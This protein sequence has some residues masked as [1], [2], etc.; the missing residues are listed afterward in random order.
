M[1]RN[2]ALDSLRGLAALAVALGHSNL[3]VTGLGPWAATVFDFPRMEAEAIAARLAYVL[4]PSDA[5][6]V[7]FFVLSGHVLWA[8][9]ARHPGGLLSGLPDWTL[10]RLYRLFPVIIA[11]ALPLALL[12]NASVIELVEDMLLLSHKLNGPAW[13]LQVELLASLA[14]FLVHRAVGGTMRGAGIAFC[15][16]LLICPLLRR[17]G[18]DPAIYFP[19]FLAGALI[20]AIPAGGWRP[21]LLL[22]GL[23]A[24][25]L[26]SLF[27]GHGAAGR[28]V[29]TLGAVLVVGTVG[30]WQPRALLQPVPQFL[31]RISYPLY[32]SHARTDAGWA[33]GRG[34]RVRHLWTDSGLCG[35]VPRRGGAGRLVS[36]RRGRGADDGGAAAVG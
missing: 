34:K 2:R 17:L 35:G 13:S 27:L 21:W 7:L 8:A 3:A 14:L 9:C 22:P 31:G 23:A 30:A 28:G 6:V 11:S 29:E 32:L 16:S 5:A 25:L 4:F 26:G 24:L 18:L 20:N 12:R 36:A 19:A 15:L 10:A 1:P 33:C